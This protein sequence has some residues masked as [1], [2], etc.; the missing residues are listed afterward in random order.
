MEILVATWSVRLAAVAAVAVGAVSVSTGTPV[1]EAVIRANAAA[2]AFTLG[3]RL[4]LGVLEPPDQ[5]LR[6]AMARRATNGG[7]S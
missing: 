7:E 6:R 4:L 5:R 1:L 3:G 2:F